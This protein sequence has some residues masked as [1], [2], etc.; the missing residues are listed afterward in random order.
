VGKLGIA[1]FALV[2]CLAY[3]S[4]LKMEANFS[5]ETS[6]GLHGTTCRYIREEEAR[7]SPLR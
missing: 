7:Q 5:S 1:C 2:S 6:V 4:S 3:S